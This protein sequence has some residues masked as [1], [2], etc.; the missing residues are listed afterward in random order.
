MID[1]EN[2]PPPQCLLCGEGWGG[3]GIEGVRDGGFLTLVFSKT[4]YYLPGAASGG[5]CGGLCVY[6]T[7]RRGRGNHNLLF[8]EKG[9]CILSVVVVEVVVVVVSISIRWWYLCWQSQRQL[10]LLLKT[11]RIAPLCS[12]VLVVA[13][14]VAVAVAAA[15]LQSGS[16]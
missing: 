2:T 4:S 16:G 1:N 11:K 3:A 9:R 10:A 8:E 5:R 12:T 13:G 7:A 6:S 14:F 15:G